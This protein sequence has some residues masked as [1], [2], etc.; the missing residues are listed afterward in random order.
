MASTNNTSL[1]Q[2]LGR[3]GAALG[4]PISGNFELTPRCNLRCKMC[5]VRLTPEQMV[6][7]GKELTAQQWIQLGQEA[8]DAGM[9]FLLLTGGEPTLRE[10]FCE[11]YEALSQMGLSISIN[12]NGTMLTPEIRELWERFPPA[13][14][15]VTVYGTCPEDYGALC[16]NPQAFYRMVDGVEWLQRQKI[17]VQLNATMAPSNAHRWQ[18]IE[19]FAK[20][21]NLEVRMATYC[22]P[23][24]RRSECGTCSDYSRLL[25]EDAA[26]VA[27][28]DILYREGAGAILRRWEH[29]NVH[30]L[31]ECALEVGEPMKCLA[32]RSLFWVAWNG[33]ISPCGMLDQP[34]VQL[35]EHGFS[36]AWEIL[37]QETD[38][39]RLCPDCVN[40]ADRASCHNCAAVTYTETGSFDGKP[41]YMCQ[42]NKAYR[43]LLE[44]M[45]NELSPQKTP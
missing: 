1:R 33:R 45:A 10:D 21:R 20:S 18:E 43:R 37:K 2:Y 17:V 24:L 42:Y 7:L 26:R 4:L 6:P 31:S 40:C 22:F 32:G 5:Y 11:I 13:Q 29:I 34:C 28:Q 25:P 14:V 9:L 3:R 44:K 30:E 35:R 15:N 8:R 39:I 16:G 38:S 36:E 12:T 23:P 19:S 27:L 41:E